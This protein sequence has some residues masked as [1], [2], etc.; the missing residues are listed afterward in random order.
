MSRQSK[1]TYRDIHGRQSA[2]VGTR[3]DNRVVMFNRSWS[4][5]DVDRVKQQLKEVFDFWGRWN[6]SSNAVADN[7]R[8]GISP[9]P[10]PNPVLDE[11]PEWLLQ[12]LVQRQRIP[13]EPLNEHGFSVSRVPL[14]E[15]ELPYREATLRRHLASIN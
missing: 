10:I 4:S 9:V 14:P 5:V 13:I 11:R 3:S 1:G 12:E 8:K 6:D 15:I 7:L 2:R